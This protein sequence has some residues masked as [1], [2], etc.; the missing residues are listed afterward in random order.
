MLRMGNAGQLYRA[1]L[2]Y[3]R[4]THSTAAITGRTAPRRAKGRWP[5]GATIAQKVLA[6]ASGRA[7]VEVGEIVWAKVDL[8]MMSDTSGPRRI[9]AGLERLGGKVWDPDKVTVISDHFVPASDDT[10][11][12]IQRITREWSIAKGIQKFHFFEGIMHIVSIERGYIWPGMLMVGAD[13]HSV[14]GGAMGCMAIPVGSTEILGVVATGEI[15]LRVPETIEVRWTGALNRGVMAKDMM[16]STLRRL[17]CDGATYQSIEYTGPGVTALPI[18]ERLVLSNMTIELGGKAGVVP[19]DDLT[20]AYLESRGVKNPTPVRSDPDARYAQIIE[21]DASLLVPQVALPHSPDNGVDIGEAAGMQMDLAYIG[22]CTGA[23]YH[24]LAIVAEILRGRTI[25]SSISMMVAPASKEVLERA[26]RDGLV[27]TIV[28][29]GAHFVPSSC[30]ACLGVGPNALKAN[31]RCISSTNRNFRG[32]MGSAEAD[33]YL[34]SP[35]T[36]AATALTGRIADPRD[37]LA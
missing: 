22:A 18:D 30:G 20:C 32:R 6:R 1:T 27:D 2:N 12:A 4:T 9:A 11:A 33:V 5:V 10:E 21:D 16:L 35:A 36:V 23:K 17:R 31:V 28:A 37:Y 24:D 19:A 29:S 13:S 3:L 14:T 26:T 8:A 15:W 7:E 34:A 25:S